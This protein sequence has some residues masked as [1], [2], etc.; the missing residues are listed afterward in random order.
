MVVPCPEVLLNKIERSNKITKK[1]ERA[2]KIARKAIN[3]H[4]AIDPRVSTFIH[5]N[6]FSS[7]KM[8]L[9]QYTSQGS[10][11]VSVKAVTGL[12]PAHKEEYSVYLTFRGQSLSHHATQMQW[13]VQVLSKHARK[14]ITDKKQV[15][16]S[17][18]AI[19]SKIQA[20][21]TALI[22]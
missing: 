3:K 13:C 18:E 9:R 21:Q 14:A 10:T 8:V 5:A 17:S 12:T 22:Q 6:R 2:N 11:G 1:A 16:K 4:P 19:R 7:F 20:K 15:K